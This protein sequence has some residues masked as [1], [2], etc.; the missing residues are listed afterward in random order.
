MIVSLNELESVTRKAFRGAGYHWGEAE[1]AGKAAVWL[2]R[3]G[4][5][6]EIIA[7][8]LLRAADGNVTRL[9]PAA[10]KREWLRSVDAICPL[11]AGIMLADEARGMMEGE[12][13]DFASLQAPGFLLPFLSQLA[14]VSALDFRL[15]V[16]E[17]EVTASLH[18]FQVTGP[19]E[20]LTMPSKARLVACKRSADETS[21]FAVRK[22]CTEITSQGWEALSYF[23]AKTYVPASDH[24]RLSGAGAGVIDSD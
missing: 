15:A 18:G 2:A 17:L 21:N 12:Y 11:L 13:V 14:C 9:R 8:S 20:A 5:A 1:E 6:S 3:E 22:H 24:S 19:S 23:A 10:D 4:L 7:L 16:T